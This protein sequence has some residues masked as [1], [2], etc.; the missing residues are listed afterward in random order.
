M[1]FSEYFKQKNKLKKYVNLFNKSFSKKIYSSNNSNNKIRDSLNNFKVKNEKYFKNKKKYLKKICINGYIFDFQMIKNWLQDFTGN[2]ELI[3]N[4]INNSNDGL[5]IFYETIGTL[6]YC[7]DL[8][9][10]L[11][12]AQLLNLIKNKIRIRISKKR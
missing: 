11:Q 10:S 3:I 5:N 9:I 7:R 6:L 1:K 4:L 8:D 12:A 2:Q